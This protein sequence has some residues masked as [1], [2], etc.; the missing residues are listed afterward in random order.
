MPA[1]DRD[2]PAQGPIFLGTT[3]STVRRLLVLTP[4]RYRRPR[5]SRRG[6]A[7]GIIVGA[8]LV[9]GILFTVFSGPSTSEFS[10]Q[11]KHYLSVIHNPCAHSEVVDTTR[12]HSWGQEHWKWP[13]DETLVED[14]HGVCAIENTAP[15]DVKTPTGGTSI[16]ARHPNYFDLQV[17]LEE[18][19]ARNI[20]CP[21]VME[22]AGE[23]P[24][25]AA[26]RPPSGTS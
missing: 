3:R 19:A 8:F 20:Y 4:P 7:A 12:C 25:M 1:P 9:A 6:R 23:S 14:A 5:V 24:S 10:A 15:S 21:N 13:D 2:G 18:V 26:V 17:G 16:A 22:P 11:D